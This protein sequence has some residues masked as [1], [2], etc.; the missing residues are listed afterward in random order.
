MENVRMIWEHIR[1]KYGR[2]NW[3][4]WRNGFLVEILGWLYAQVGLWK[5]RTTNYFV[6][7][8]KL[9]IELVLTVLSNFEGE[10]A[11]K[12]SDFWL[13]K[14]L[15]NKA[16]WSV[17]NVILKWLAWTGIWFGM[18]NTCNGVWLNGVGYQIRKPM[19]NLIRI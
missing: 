19:K 2:K 12:D 1:V 13:L 14:C 18:F 10:V 17:H 7:F 5:W 11:L 16:L 9:K 8:F 6:A 15:T 4:M 3:M